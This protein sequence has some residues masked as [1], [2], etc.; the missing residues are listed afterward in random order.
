MTTGRLV[1]EWSTDDPQLAGIL[2]GIAALP[3][4]SAARLECEA[5]LHMTEARACWAAADRAHEWDRRR[6]GRGS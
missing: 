4:H 5:Q 2:R 6:A 1:T 3:E